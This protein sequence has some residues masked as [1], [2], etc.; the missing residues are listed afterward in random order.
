MK[1]ILRKKL[2]NVRKK[3]SW[4]EVLIKSRKIEHKLFSLKEFKNSSTILF[5]VSYNNEVYTHDMIKKCIASDKNVVAPVVDKNNNCL[6]LSR[7]RR[8]EDLVVGTYGILEPRKEKIDEVSVDDIDLIIV[9]GVG[10]DEKGYRV[11]H[12]MG[13]YDRLLKLSK[14]LHIG[15]AFEFQIIKSIPHDPYDV[16]VD[17]IVT[18]EKVIYC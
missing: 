17:I 14:V 13:Y 3:L 5:Y 2:I 9:P 15:L 7:L 6:I 12:G 11:G 18:E 16:P 10:F 4:E 1:N 8:W